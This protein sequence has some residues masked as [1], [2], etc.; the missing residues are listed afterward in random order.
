MPHIAFPVGSQT[1]SG[2]FVPRQLIPGVEPGGSRVGRSKPA[3]LLRDAKL[4]ISDIADGTASPDYMTVTVNLKLSQEPN[5]D[6]GLLLPIAQIQVARRLANDFASLSMH[7][8]WMASGT[9]WAAAYVGIRL[10][11][12]GF[13]GG[14][15]SI[16]HLDYDEI[17]QEW[18]DWF[19][20]WD[21]L[22][23]VVNNERQ[24]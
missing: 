20:R 14:F 11:I 4:Q 9:I 17:E 21:F 16:V 13:A 15:N 8:L 1:S 18:M 23:N 6:P 24:Y 3:L 7:D 2:D 22:D 12:N 5:L 19:I 10:E